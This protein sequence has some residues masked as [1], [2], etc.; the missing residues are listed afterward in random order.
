[1]NTMRGKSDARNGD[2]KLT[3][4]IRKRKQSAD[5][6]KREFGDVVTIDNEQSPNID[7]VDTTT[8]NNDSGSENAIGG[9]TNGSERNID[10]DGSG[11]N[12]SGGNGSNDNGS[13]SS[14]STERRKPGRPRKSE[15]DST[16]QIGQ[17]AVYVKKR[18]R[19]PNAAK[20]FLPDGMEASVLLLTGLIDSLSGLVAVSTATPYLQL[21][22]PESQELAKALFDCLESMPKAMRKRFDQVFAKYYPFWNLAIVSTKIAYP[23]YQMYRAEQIIRSYDNVSTSETTQVN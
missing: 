19:K 22:K 7:S 1:M 23:R 9:F 15:T 4:A 16:K 14:A 5:K 20:D 12:G 17:D 11:R 10:G 18:V 21:Q 6:S 3:S 8:R 13:D 2:S